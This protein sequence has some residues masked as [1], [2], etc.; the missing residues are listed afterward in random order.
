MDNPSH[1]PL[2]KR[3]L[4]LIDYN[5]N[6][7]D[8]FLPRLKPDRLES[9]SVQE[10]METGLMNSG[11][12][13]SRCPN[14]PDLEPENLSVHSVSRSSVKAPETE[15]EVTRRCLVPFTLYYQL[16]G[17]AEEVAPQNRCHNL[18]AAQPPLYRPY[19]LPARPL[20]P[21]GG[22]FA[23]LGNRSHQQPHERELPPHLSPP[24]QPEQGLPSPTRTAAVAAESPACAPSPAAGDI[25]RTMLNRPPQ[26]MLVAPTDVSLHSSV[27]SSAVERHQCSTCHKEYGTAAGLTRHCQ[28]HCQPRV[29]PCDTCHKVYT[30]QGALKMHIRTHTLPNK[31]EYC[32]KAFSRPWLLQGHIRT[33]TGEK[34]FQCD[35]CHRSFA[36]KSNLRA[37]KQT[38]NEVKKYMCSGCNKTFSRMSLL[39]KHEEGGCTSLHVQ[40]TC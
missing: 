21:I 20:F 34:P 31:C 7:N 37:H 16:P 40:S 18:A 13:P 15:K 23:G 8:G 19:A 2:K 22:L 3:P 27:L 26:T 36:D 4:A 10:R 1:K 9:V 33:H 5:S 39:S 14:S 38:H 17:T 12:I 35:L 28:Q 6:Q 25:L 32:G 24:V 30:S 29:F 11:I